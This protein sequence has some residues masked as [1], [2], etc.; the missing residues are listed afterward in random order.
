MVRLLV[1]GE[2]AAL[3]A[4][5]LRG[6]L[7]E[8]LLSYVVNGGVLREERE[9]R[10]FPGGR[11]G[12]STDWNGGGDRRIHEGARSAGSDCVIRLLVRGQP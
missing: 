9:D 1:V 5:M 10:R 3:R 4:Y 7:I 11:A 2:V 6:R 8:S 12:W